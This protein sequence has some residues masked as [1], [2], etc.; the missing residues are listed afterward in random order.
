[1]P[2]KYRGV[3]FI[4]TT[5]LGHQVTMNDNTTRSVQERITKAKGSW[6]A[7]ERRAFLYNDINVA[8]GIQL[9][10]TAI[11]SILKYGLCALKMSDPVMIKLQQFC[12]KCIRNIA[13]TNNSD[14]RNNQE[15]IET[16]ENWG[17]T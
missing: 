16:N 6:K 15:Q 17:K 8:V 4:K 1:M 7:I 13:E 14:Y 12:S 5:L 2:R 11:Y 9:W 3:K 10:N